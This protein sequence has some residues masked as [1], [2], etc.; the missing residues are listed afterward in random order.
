MNTFHYDALTMPA[1]Y[2]DMTAAFKGAYDLLRTYLA[3]TV[4]QNGHEVKF[5]NMTDEEP[6]APIYVGTFNLATAPSGGPLPSPVSLCCSFQGDRVSGQDQARRRGRVYLGE[7]DT[8]QIDMAGR[9][10]STLVGAVVAFGQ[11]LLDASESDVDYTWC[12]FST[13]DQTLTPI[14]NGWCDNVFDI[15]RRRSLTATSR[16]LFS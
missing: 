4:S 9:P 2:A 16:S 5:Y 12:V 15:Q 7:W 13:V 10:S 8:T 3:E 1:P 11:Y 14:T 6:R